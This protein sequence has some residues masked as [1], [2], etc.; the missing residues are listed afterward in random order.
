MSYDHFL[1]LDIIGLFIILQ[2]DQKKC[3]ELSQSL[4]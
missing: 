1:E 3:S 2:G 4:G